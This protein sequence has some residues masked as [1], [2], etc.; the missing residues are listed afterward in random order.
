MLAEA[1]LHTLDPFAIQ[2]TDGFGL[3]WYGL[4]YLAGFIIAWVLLRWIAKSGRSPLEPIDIPDLMVAAILGVLIGGRLGYCLFYDQSLFGFSDEFPFWGVLAIQRGGMAS[5]GGMIGVI[6]ALL[7]F[8]HRRNVSKLHVLDLSALVAAPGL[9]LGRVANFINAELWGRALPPEMQADPPAWSV[10]YPEEVLRWMLDD[11]GYEGQRQA[12]FAMRPE[13]GGPDKPLEYAAHIVRLIDNGN[14]QAIDAIQP[15]LTAYYP[16]QLVQ[17]LT[18]GPILFA[19]LAIVW[20]RPRKPGVLGSWFLIAYG[21]LRI[22]SEFVR[23]PDEGVALLMGLSRGQVL[24]IVMV[25]AGI[26]ALVITSRRKAKKMGGWPRPEPPRDET[27]DARPPLA[28]ETDAAESSP[29]STSTSTSTS[30][31]ASPM[32]DDDPP[33]PPS[34]LDPAA[35]ADETDNNGDSSPPKGDDGPAPPLRGG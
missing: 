24:S 14:Q 10:K 3:R 4:S 32:K 6:I 18:D 9:G 33:L 35:D 28:V 17:A 13:L 1:F 30:A 19:V 29:P 20:L 25:L 27:N 7:W 8:A 22:S 34:A 11:S 31:P 2:L 26:V 21:V 16:S 5:H 23:Q 15:L 12:L